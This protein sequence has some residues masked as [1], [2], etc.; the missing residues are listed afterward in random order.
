MVAAPSADT[1][2]FESAVPSYQT[3]LT[4]GT[5]LVIV[6]GQATYRGVYDTNDNHASIQTTAIAN[7]EEN[8]GNGLTK[9]GPFF[10]G[11]VL[12]CTDAQ[13]GCPGRIYVSR[14]DCRFQAQ[15]I[16]RGRTVTAIYHQFNPEIS[17]RL[18]PSRGVP[19][20]D[21]PQTPPTPD[22]PCGFVEVDASVVPV[23][24]GPQLVHAM[25]ATTFSALRR[26]ARGSIDFIMDEWAILAVE[27]ADGR[28]DRVE[29]LAASSDRY[30]AFRLD[31]LVEAIEVTRLS[32][33]GA[34]RWDLLGKGSLESY[35][36]PGRSILL[37]VD[38]P[39]HPHNH[40]WIEKPV[41]RLL[42]GQVLVPEDEALAVVRAEYGDD[43]SLESMEVLYSDRPL[44]GN[45]L[46]YLSSHLML[47]Y[48]SSQSH[49][50][51][52]FAV[53]Q[54]GETPSL[55]VSKV[56]VA[57]CCCPSSGPGEPCGSGPIAA[58]SP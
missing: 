43:R 11:Y 13:S 58:D 54:L 45:D 26:E 5:I 8:M 23:I 48:S 27:K 28:V 35:F 6:N 31:G 32:P 46:S 41:P 53:V 29:L 9:D 10:D 3:Q 52:L 57:Q 30:A 37:A 44:T 4:P 2:T 21:V 7:G 55:R 24:G 56:V 34:G 19:C 33:D 38:E 50:A 47:E 42:G 20:L 16:Y 36:R 18:A 12:P 15:P 1:G 39:L 51:V 40:R 22:L 49:R 14:P 25:P 17:T